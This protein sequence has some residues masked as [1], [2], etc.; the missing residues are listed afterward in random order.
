[1]CTIALH[2]R[3][4]SFQESAVFRPFGHGMASMCTTSRLKAYPLLRCRKPTLSGCLSRLVVV[5]CNSESRSSS[6]MCSI[7]GR[8]FP[9]SSHPQVGSGRMVAEYRVRVG[10]DATKVG[11]LPKPP[12]AQP[13]SRANAAY[14]ARMESGWISKLYSSITVEMPSSVVRLSRYHIVAE[15]IRESAAAPVVVRA[16]A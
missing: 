12:N 5:R 4:Q 10:R 9:V 1:M 6:C 2:S 14:S 8:R 15:R 16:R 3:R 11:W 13:P 7:P